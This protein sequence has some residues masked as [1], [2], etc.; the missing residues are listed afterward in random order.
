MWRRCFEGLARSAVR[1]EFVY[2]RLPNNRRCDQPVEPHVDFQFLERQVPASCRQTAKTAPDV[3]RS[4]IFSG[5]QCR[6][7]IGH[8][9]LFPG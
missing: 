9:F 8:D 2:E 3:V 1:R 6:K 5:I 4:R 7:R